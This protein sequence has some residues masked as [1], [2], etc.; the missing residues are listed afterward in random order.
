MHLDFFIQKI[1]P[2]SLS[3]VS[4]R[5]FNNTGENSDF[6]S[7]L[8]YRIQLMEMIEWGKNSKPKQILNQK[9]TPQK[10]HDEFP[11]LKIFIKW[12]NTKNK[13]EIECLCLR[14]GYADTITSLQI[15]LNPP[16]NPC[17][18][19]TNQKILAKFFYP[20]HLGIENL[21]PT[22]PPPSFDQPVTWNPEYPLPSPLRWLLQVTNEFIWTD[23]QGF[24]IGAWYNLTIFHVPDDNFSSSESRSC[25]I[26]EM[27]KATR[28]N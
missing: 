10:S 2:S 8:R 24:L 16:K 25:S 6:R 26:K 27:T 15:V 12:Y 18:K 19:T 14:L 3:I 1:I 11:S 28:N 17:L 21:P 9:L 5:L 23:N 20:K 4:H 13:S 7:G 22:P